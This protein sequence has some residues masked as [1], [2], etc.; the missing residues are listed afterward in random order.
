[1]VVLFD[2]DAATGGTECAA[3]E[4]LDG[5]QETART[6]VARFVALGGPGDVLDGEDPEHQEEAGRKRRRR[7]DLVD[8]R[9][10][11]LGAREGGLVVRMPPFSSSSSSTHSDDDNNDNNDNDRL[12]RVPYALP[13]VRPAYRA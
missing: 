3:R 7:L 12:C 9:D 5:G 11:L 13:F 10:F 8:C 6:V 4:L 2:D 1:R